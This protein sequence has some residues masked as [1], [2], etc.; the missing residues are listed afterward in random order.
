MIAIHDDNNNESRAIRALPLILRNYL[1]AVSTA[2]TRRARRRAA[3]LST[4][5]LSA[6]SNA[7]GCLH[8]AAAFRGL[9][10]AAAA[11]ARSP[12]ARSHAEMRALPRAYAYRRPR[13]SSASCPCTLCVGMCVWCSMP[14]GRVAACRIAWPTS[15]QTKPVFLNT[16]ALDAIIRH[17]LT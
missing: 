5:S 14:A 16:T 2:P 8:V 15:H 9:R 12:R 10:R 7:V 11:A 17:G 4:L 6:F 1:A 13:V 3:F